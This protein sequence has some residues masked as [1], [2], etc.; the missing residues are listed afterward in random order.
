MKW[1]YKNSIGCYMA[2]LVACTGFAQNNPIFKGGQGD[3]FARA[4]YKQNTANVFKG[5][6]GDGW[7]AK[8]YKQ[9]TTNIFAGGTG[10]GWSTAAYLQSTTSIF[11]GGAGD[12][13]GSNKYVQNTVSIFKG[14]QGD[15]WSKAQFEQQTANIYTGGAGDGWASSYRPQAPLPVTFV[16]FTAQKQGEHTA[17]VQWKTATEFNAGWFEVERSGDAVN[18]EFI[19]KVL[20]SSNAAG[21]LYSFTDNSPIKGLNYYRLKQVDKDNRFTYT[22]ARLLKFTETAAGMVRYYPNPTNGILNIEIS[23][24]MRTENLIVNIS[25]SSGAVLNQLKVAAGASS[26][27][28][29]YLNRYS[30]GIYFIQVKTPSTNSTQRVVLQ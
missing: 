26:V 11:K 17:L 30:K 8:S 24:Q 27:L 18:F 12:G 3:G 15:G 5:G 13:W 28:Q 4:G 9:A 25:N 1:K 22:P 10:H 7:S 20:A 29:V 23:S 16:F 19:G 21:M 6:G 2:M 14:G